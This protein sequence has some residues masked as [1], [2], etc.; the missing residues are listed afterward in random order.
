[1]GSGAA[2]VGQKLSERLGIPFVDRQILK[3]VAARLRMAEAEL[4]D[5]EQRLLTF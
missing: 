3:Q 5:R 2:Y 4:V 1:M